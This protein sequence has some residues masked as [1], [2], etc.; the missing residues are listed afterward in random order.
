M[1]QRFFRLG[2]G[3]FDLAQGKF[4][5]S[6]RRGQ[7][8]M[9]ERRRHPRAQLTLPVR[10]RW[11]MPLGQLTE[12]TETLDVCR[13]GLLVYRR[14]PCPVG[15]TLWV[16]VPFDSALSLAQPETP[17]RVARVKETPTGGHLVGIAFEPLRQSTGAA[18]TGA[19]RRGRERISL[20]LPIRVRPAGAPWPEEAMTVDISDDGVRFSTA[21][22]YQAGDSVRITLPPG[23]P[24][25]EWGST[26]EVPARVVRVAQRPGWVEQEVAVVLLI[27]LGL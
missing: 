6:P 23:T 21:R 25:S 1:F 27:A 14:E 19:D 9:A 15:A 11:P 20:A 18:A 5:D 26:A 3:S 17:A 10:L 24:G 7:T 22:L 4:F 13:S 12:V 16:T 8:P 2:S